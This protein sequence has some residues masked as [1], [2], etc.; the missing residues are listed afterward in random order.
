M[1]DFAMIIGEDFDFDVAWAQ[2]AERAGFIME[3]DSPADQQAEIEALDD[4]NNAVT[5]LDRQVQRAEATLNDLP[6]V[7]LQ[8]AQ[9]ASAGVCSHN[10]QTI[11][12]PE[13]VQAPYESDP[14][15][16]RV[17][18]LRHD[19]YT[20]LPED[21]DAA[22][23][24]MDDD[25]LPPQ[26]FEVDEEDNDNND[27]Q[28]V[29]RPEYNVCISDLTYHVNMY[30][31]VPPAR[32]TALHLFKQ[33][34]IS[35]VP[36]ATQVQATGNDAVLLDEMVFS[37]LI[38]QV[39]D[40]SDPGDKIR[41]ICAQ[42]GVWVAVRR[43]PQARRGAGQPWP[44]DHCRLFGCV[45]RAEMRCGD[46]RD[47]VDDALRRFHAERPWIGERQE[48]ERWA[49]ER[50]DDEERERRRDARQRRWEDQRRRR[51]EQ[52]R[53]RRQA[54][55]ERRWTIHVERRLEERELQAGRERERER[56][57]LR[58]RA[59]RWGRHGRFIARGL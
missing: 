59:R 16:I 50:A 41:Q 43:G 6:P 49:R 13:F 48:R 27:D 35:F 22:E 26:Q 12:Q 52:E 3:F 8:Y 11:H 19:Y 54:E 29:W 4:L 32:A 45:Q 23:A 21:A 36:R 57:L 5:D 51:R 37:H 53:V 38:R 7:A 25:T 30:N 39:Y 31:H 10:I 55:E 18:S 15:P 14:T 1:A 40:H 24:L 34:L 44:P 20:A 46:F 28:P 56:R 33:C 58:V 42:F 47:D 2:Q 17:G 9:Y